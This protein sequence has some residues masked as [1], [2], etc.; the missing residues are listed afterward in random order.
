MRWPERKPSLIPEPY[1]ENLVNAA[2]RTDSAVK[3]IYMP[4]FCKAWTSPVNDWFNTMKND[5]RQL[6]QV[7]VNLGNRY[8]AFGPPV[9]RPQDL[10][11][12]PEKDSELLPRVAEESEVATERI[13]QTLRVHGMERLAGIE[14]GPYNADLVLAD[15][16]GQRTFI[17]IKVR[18]HDPKGRELT[19][20]WARAKEANATA[21]RLEIW[22]FNIERLC[23]F[24]ITQDGNTP[25]L[26]EMPP[27]DVWEKTEQGIF[28]RAR[29][30]DEVEDWEKRI[31][32][33]Y[34]DVQSWFAAHGHV[35]FDQTRAVTMS[36]ELMQKYAVSERKLPV[37]DVLRQDQVSASF[38][39]RGLWILGAHG[40]IDI[41]MQEET[42]ILIALKNQTQH[43]DW[44]LVS[45]DNNRKTI[46]FTKDAFLEMLVHP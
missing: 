26:Y 41:I 34:A 9:G 35:K 30:A 12:D 2:F 32:Q 4:V 45:F 39:P 10:Q 3:I 24:I 20:A 1:N 33:L 23:L 8:V 31:N 16:N 14:L 28:R 44:H 36:E 43:Y 37:L 11:F 40:R 18:D 6:P 21:N 22:H 25:N 42:R 29:V 19:G 27:M 15:V 7:L 17:E 46:P 38:V 5:K 13:V